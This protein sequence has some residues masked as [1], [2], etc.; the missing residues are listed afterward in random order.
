[1]WRKQGIVGTAQEIVIQDE[2]LM[3][4]R[5]SGGICRRNRSPESAP[6][7]PIYECPQT[8]LLTVLFLRALII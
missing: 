1:M 5:D 6:E 2:K 4:G 3:R 7:L 8:S